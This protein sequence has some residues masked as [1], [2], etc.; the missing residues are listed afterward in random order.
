MSLNDLLNVSLVCKRWRAVSR[1]NTIWEKFCNRKWS[2]V[3]DPSP[4]RLPPWHYFD[5]YRSHSI[6]TNCWIKSEMPLLCFKGHKK[7][8]TAIH[9]NAN[10]MITGDSEKNLRIW[11]LKFSLPLRIN[12]SPL[13]NSKKKKEMSKSKPVKLK[14]KS[15]GNHSL[16][17]SCVQ[18]SDD[19]S[20]VFSGS[21]DN[22]IKVWDLKTKKNCS[23]FNQHKDHITSIH[24]INDKILSS[25]KDG[26]LYLLDV[27]TGDKILGLI[28]AH[29]DSINA[30]KQNADGSLALTCSSDHL[31]KLWDLRQKTA[32]HIFEGH[33]DVISGM[34]VDPDFS[35]FITC[36]SD[37]S[38]HTWDMNRRSLMVP[39]MPPAEENNTNTRGIIWTNIQADDD[40]IVLSM[41]NSSLLSIFDR[42]TLTKVKTLDS[43]LS[44][45]HC[46]H[47]FGSSM[48]AGGNDKLLRLWNPDKNGCLFLL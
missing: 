39:I 27:Q 18:I 3:S 30:V 2:S 9:T 21:L 48:L 10:C 38:I 47:L 31:I 24:A 43:A 44:T 15:F 13:T 23:T 22:T 19:G 28:D 36:S 42:R 40:K 6:F 45:V 41:A 46:L 33:R 5:Q 1:G 12:S 20:K 17:I 32:A 11:T 35:E 26:H 29:T 34:F 14:S 37:G 7:P 16:A 4:H 8:I 25:S